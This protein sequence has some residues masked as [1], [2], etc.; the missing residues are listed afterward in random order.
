MAQAATN[1]IPFAF[2]DRLVRAVHKNDEPWLVGKDV[3]EILRIKDYHQA[4]ER[5]DDDERGGCSV[6]TPSG[7]Q[8][9]IIVSEP[10]VYRL[11]FTSRRPEAERF[12][13]WLAHEVLPAIRKTGRFEARQPGEE[14]VILPVTTETAREIEIKL[15]MVNTAARI[16]G[17]ER[18]R[19]VWRE[20]GLSP[21]PVP[22]PGGDYEALECLEHIF[23]AQHEGQMVI[24]LLRAAMD[25]DKDAAAALKRGGLWA[26]P[27]RDGFVVANRHGDL[28]KL[29]EDTAWRDNRWCYVL[30]RLPGAL[31]EKARRFVAG[32]TSRGVF[33]PG[34]YIDSKSDIDG[35][36]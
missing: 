1:I 14:P 19:A 13:R 16:F 21:V 6:P 29:F 4:L 32:E 26:E 12:K 8:I 35:R 24:R 27:D 33:I 3:C 30:R 31:R 9:M 23:S 36:S 28:S 34:H 2:E 20:Q 25:D 18:A 5:L 17:A 10:G 7:E 11:I 15:A 22:A